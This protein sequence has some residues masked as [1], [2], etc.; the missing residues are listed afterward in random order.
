MKAFLMYQDQDIDLKRKL[1]SN[2][3]ELIQDLELTTLF[4]AMALDDEFLYDVAKHT[5]LS[6]F[7]HNPPA[8]LYRQH[9]LQ[10]CLKNAAIIREIYAIA[11]QAIEGERQHYWG[12][13]SKYPA[14]ILSRSLEI[15]QMFV[16]QLKQLRQIA[17]EQADRFDSKGFTRFFVMLRQ[18]LTD[19][20][21]IK[22]QEHLKELKFRDGVLISAALGPGNKGINYTLRRPHELNQGW[23]KR[24]FG[25]KPPEFSFSIHPRDESGARALSELQDRGI[26][27]VANA[28]A[29]S[30]EHILSFFTMLRT[31]LAFYIGC[32]NVYEQ[33]AQLGEPLCFPQPV[34]AKERQHTVQGLYDVCLALTMQQKIVGNTVKA[35]R[36]NLMIITGANQGGKSTFLAA[37]GWRN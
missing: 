11:I 6:G 21:F 27:L 12:M 36:K 28:L 19:E 25:P 31:E 32:L 1:P 7:S 2:Q 35:D 18:E 34:A 14:T 10:D 22:V 26:N 4:N 23:I 9:I 15:M 17:D 20:Y 5:V 24:I 33:L 13:F 37:S 29:Q 8:I 3:H 16:G 30:T